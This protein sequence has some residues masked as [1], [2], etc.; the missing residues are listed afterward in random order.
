M[1]PDS[2]APADNILAYATFIISS[3]DVHPDTWT[4]LFGVFPSRT[5]T[6]GK[7]YL[8]PSGRLGSRPGKLNLW[9]LESKPA[10]HSDRLE[11]HLRYLID[12]LSLPRD[13]L[14]E[15]IERADARMRFFC[16]WDNETGNR[17][18]YVSE[19]TRKLIESIG[20]VLEIDEY[21]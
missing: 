12:R 18:P 14:R 2:L 20:G 9:A 19:A 21:R 17:V 7:P 10:V 6:R 5:I 8:L 4:A 15:R 11:P 13:D 16:Y 1:H 3:E